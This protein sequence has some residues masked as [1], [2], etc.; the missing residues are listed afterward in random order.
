ML[1]IFIQGGGTHTL[2]FAAGQ[3]GLEHIGGIQS[4]LGRTG[5]DHRM[6]LINEKYDL[7][8]GALDL[9]DG[10]FEPFLEFTPEARSSYHRA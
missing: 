9:L 8:L 6:Q 7:A 2:Q 1:V 4:T 10:S 3:G 5:T